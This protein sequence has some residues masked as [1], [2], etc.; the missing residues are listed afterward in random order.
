MIQKVYLI[1]PVADKIWLRCGSEF[2]IIAGKWAIIVHTL[3]GLKSAR[4]AFCNHLADCMG[5]RGYKPCLV[6]PDVWMKAMTRPDYGFKYHGYMLLYFDDVLSISDNATEI[7]NKLDCYLKMK[8][9]SIGDL[10]MYFGDKLLEVT[11]PSG[12]K[13]GASAQASK[14]RK[15]SRLSRSTW[16]RTWEVGS[17]RGRL[18]PHFRVTTRQRRIQVRSW[19][20]NKPCFTVADWSFAMVCGTWASGYYSGCIQV[21][22]PGEDTQGRVP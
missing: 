11:L 17:Y 12:W 13:P 2:V 6:D 18:Q 22:I 7:L 8:P 15:P 5:T 21:G 19:L 3:H 14:S 16:G 4:A 1:V 9:G 10:D 20:Q